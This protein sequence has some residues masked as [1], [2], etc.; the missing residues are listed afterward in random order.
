MKKI[1]KTCVMCGAEVEIVV[2]DEQATEL[3][4]RNR[5]HIQDILPTHSPGERE[6]FISGIC[7]KCFDNFFADTG[8]DE[9]C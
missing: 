5:R 3:Q 1:I 4:S 8:D 7:S 9:Q 2:T 6:M